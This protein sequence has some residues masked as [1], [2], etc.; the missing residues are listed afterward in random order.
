MKENKAVIEQVTMALGGGEA[1]SSK[2]SKTGFWAK[3]L[4]FGL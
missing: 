1:V 3:R 2:G 4:E